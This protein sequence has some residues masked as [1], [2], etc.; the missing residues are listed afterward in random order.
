MK[1]VSFQESVSVINDQPLI[2]ELESQQIQHGCFRSPSNKGVTLETSDSDVVQVRPFIPTPQRSVGFVVSRQA[3][4]CHLFLLCPQEICYLDQVLDAASETPTNG[5]PSLSTHSE[6][7]SIDGAAPSVSVSASS[8]ANHRPIV[9]ER[10]RQTTFV[11]QEELAGRTN[12]HGPGDESGHGRAQ[13]ELR[14]FQEERRPAKLFTPGEEQ[15]VRVTRRRNSEEVISCSVL[16]RHVTSCSGD[17]NECAAAVCT[18]TARMSVELFNHMKSSRIFSAKLKGQ[19]TSKYMCRGL[20]MLQREDR[21]KLYIRVEIYESRPKSLVIRYFTEIR[22][23][24]ITE[25]KAKG[26]EAESA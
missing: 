9:V 4:E 8:P 11:H 1:S 3:V 2:M 10:P 14:A 19:Q 16:I 13:F 24:E 23:S 5:N 22:S 15:Q 12:G 20:V 7:I 6:P 17:E 18:T 25:Y 26:L 21:V